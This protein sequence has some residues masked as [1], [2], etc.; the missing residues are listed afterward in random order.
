M[1]SPS[2]P[3]PRQNRCDRV[4][5]PIGAPGEANKS[6]S[7][8]SHTPRRHPVL[9]M[10]SAPWNFDAVQFAAR[11]HAQGGALINCREWWEK[12]GLRR[13]PP[14]A[15]RPIR[16]CDGD[17][18][19][20]ADLANQIRSADIDPSSTKWATTARSSFLSRFSAPMRSAR[21]S[22]H[23][24]QAAP[25]PKRSLARGLCAQPGVEY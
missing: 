20:R 5:G 15:E 4:R 22:H 17:G 2:I 18:T 10:S 9:R 24:A 7:A 12:C 25:S 1:P 8:G 19:R 21:E 14:V 6:S 23:D 16:Y 3:S 11:G 13:R